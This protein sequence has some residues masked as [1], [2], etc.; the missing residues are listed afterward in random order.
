M[1]PWHAC[2]CWNR[3]GV[4]A[5]GRPQVQIPREYPYLEAEDIAEALSYAACL[6][7]PV[8]L[9][10]AVRRRGANSNMNDLRS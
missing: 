3:L 1:Y 9:P 4:V 10:A 8:R 2:H 7:V 5:A 6:F